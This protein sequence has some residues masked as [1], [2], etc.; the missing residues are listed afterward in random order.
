MQAHVGIRLLAHFGGSAGLHWPLRRKRSAANPSLGCSASP[1]YGWQR[2]WVGGHSHSLIQCPAAWSNGTWALALQ[3]KSPCPACL[4]PTKASTRPPKPIPRKF[5]QASSLDGDPAY[6]VEIPPAATRRRTVFLVALQGMP[7]RLISGG[8]REGQ[9]Q[10]TGSE[11]AGFCP[12]SGPACGVHTRP[13]C[14]GAGTCSVGCLGRHMHPPGCQ[15]PPVGPCT[16]YHACQRRAN[17]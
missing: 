6:G 7:A 4:P 8:H 1:E 11:V 15:L 14:S 13:R 5:R 3:L 10:G 17:L 16:R 2:S 12:P 9:K